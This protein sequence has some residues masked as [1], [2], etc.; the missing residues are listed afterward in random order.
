MVT[1]VLI[2]NNDGKLKR[3]LSIT[4]QKNKHMPRKN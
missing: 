2:K 4:T 1:H 3:N